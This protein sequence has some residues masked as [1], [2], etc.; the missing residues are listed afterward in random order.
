MGRQEEHVPLA[1]SEGSPRPPFQRPDCSV[2]PPGLHLTRGCALCP[3]CER[4]DPL[5][6]QAVCAAPGASQNGRGGGVPVALKSWTWYTQGA[7]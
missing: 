3:G 6:G 4:A 1:V 5:S 7:Q 2:A